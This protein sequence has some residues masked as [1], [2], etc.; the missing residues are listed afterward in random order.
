M[1]RE[2]FPYDRTS[3]HELKFL[4]SFRFGKEDV[5]NESSKTLWE[6]FFYVHVTVQSNKFLYNRI[7]HIHQFP[8]FTPA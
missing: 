5:R 8:K 4:L 2:E 1:A 6:I 3:S 7:N